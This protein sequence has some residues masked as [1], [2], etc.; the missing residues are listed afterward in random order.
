MWTPIGFFLQAAILWIILFIVARHDADRSY[1]TLFFISLGISVVAFVSSIYI[2]Q[3]T[4]IV[5]ATVCVC[6]RTVKTSQ[7]GSNEN[8]PL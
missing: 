3:F 8:Q 2:P 6:Q 1:S 4:L 5:T 7:G